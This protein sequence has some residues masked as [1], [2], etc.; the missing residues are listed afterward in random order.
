MNK[1]MNEKT[2]QKRWKPIEKKNS[3]SRKRVYIFYE[4]ENK[5]ELENRF[6]LTIYSDL[7]IF[8]FNNSVWIENNRYSCNTPI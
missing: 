6:L 5:N 7:F 2:H 3:L 8:G 1:R 4:I